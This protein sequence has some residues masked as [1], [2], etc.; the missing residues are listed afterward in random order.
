M[1]S[2]ALGLGKILLERTQGV[3][4]LAELKANSPWRYELHAYTA[5]QPETW[6][7][8]NFTHAKSGG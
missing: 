5:M 7:N 1:V 6:N 2:N 4:K 3:D 8:A